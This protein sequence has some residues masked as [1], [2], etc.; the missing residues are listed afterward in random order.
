MKLIEHSSNFR[1]YTYVVGIDFGHGETSAAMCQ[2]L[3]DENKYIKL[4]D[5]IHLEV[6]GKD[7]RIPSALAVVE[8][9]NSKNVCYYIGN[10]A[11]EALKEKDK[12]C[13][14]FVGFKKLP[15]EMNDNDRYVTGKFMELFYKRIMEVRHSAKDLEE[16]NHVV[17]IA[18]PSSKKWTGKEQEQYLEIAR[19]AGLPVIDVEN[20]EEHY[21]KSIMKES[22]AAFIKAQ[23]A[24]NENI[25]DSARDGILLID[26]GSSTIDMTYYSQN[27][28]NKPI[29]D[30]YLCGASKVE[31]AILNYCNKPQ[32]VTAD[33]IAQIPSAKNILRMELRKSKESY[34]SSQLVMT[35]GMEI[36]INLSKYGYKNS[37]R[38]IEENLRTHTLNEILIP[39]KKEIKDC[40]AKFRDTYILSPHHPVM[41]IKLIFLTGGASRMPFVKEIAEDVFGKDISLHT[42]ANP[43]CTISDG[44]ALVGRSDLRTYEVK[45]RLFS[46]TLHPVSSMLAKRSAKA[47]ATKIISSI[48]DQISGFKES[49]VDSSIA[50][51]EADIKSSISRIP[52]NKIIAEKYDEVARENANA[53]IRKLKEITD[54]Y[55]P[56]VK[57]NEIKPDAPSPFK[58]DIASLPAIANIIN[59]CVDVITEGFWETLFKIALNILGFV[60]CAIVNTELSLLRG[61]ISV[62]NMFRDTEIKK[63]DYIDLD[64]MSVNFR[65]KDTA[66]NQNQRNEIY[67]H[68]KEI[69]DQYFFLFNSEIE[70]KMNENTEFCSDINKQNENETKD[71]IRNEINK[72][73][74]MLR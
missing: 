35:K 17:Y 8:A 37:P 39:Y 28:G 14:Y 34:F 44:V 25:K 7:D 27:L 18:C 2:V 22:R 23:N 29:D 30:S 43:S 40:M 42:E 57:I 65:N 38:R 56:N 33:F 49:T 64:E 9:Q 5:P 54:E 10:D 69:L 62:I 36:D 45:N 6:F 71:Y 20:S 32:S 12:N 47:I 48:R 73:I 1:Q 55:A 58:A 74:M 13:E 72:S 31:E 66:L 68:M 60:G 4:S 63:P 21:P 50:S 46:V 41:P 26:F 16:G 11:L 19:K 67:E 52:Y 3:W 53:H 24:K 70:D 51:L 61:A 15:S 59:R